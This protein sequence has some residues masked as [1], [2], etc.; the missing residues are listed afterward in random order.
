PSTPTSLCG[1]TSEQ[2]DAPARRVQA[3]GSPRQDQ[4]TNGTADSDI[5]GSR[6]QGRSQRYQKEPSP[7]YSQT[8]PKTEC[9]SKS[10][11]PVRARGLRRRKR[12]QLFQLCGRVGI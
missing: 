4:E 1:G 9:P 3:N 10:V 2:D 11:R 12:L 6:L 5:V 7:R 8:P